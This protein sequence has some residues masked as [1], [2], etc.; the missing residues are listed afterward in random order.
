MILQIEIIEL[1]ENISIALHYLQ[2]LD[3]FF[4]TN[5]ELRI[6]QKEI[7]ALTSAVTNLKYK[8]QKTFKDITF[9]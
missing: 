9:Q 7:T 3:V 2:K 5:D 4:E 1:M 8:I 6:F